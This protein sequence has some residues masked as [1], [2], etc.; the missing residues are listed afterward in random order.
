MSKFKVVF[1]KGPDAI[2][3]G[4]KLRF[5]QESHMLELLNDSGEVIAA[6]AQ[7]Q[8]WKKLEAE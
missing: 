7:F 3:E 1:Y 8:Y 4:E 6:F 2:V 5:D